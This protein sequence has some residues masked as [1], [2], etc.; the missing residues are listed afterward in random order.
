MENYYDLFQI[1]SNA[2]YNEIVNAYNI[3][4]KKYNYLKTLNENQINEIKILKKGLYILTSSE[5]KQK[6]DNKLFDNNNNN[7]DNLFNIDNSWM[8]KC[9]ITET[10]KKELNFSNRIFSLSE[11]NKKPNYPSD[12]RF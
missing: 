6:Y 7:L 5:L 4:I 12:L 8:D 3:K 10:N 1:N 2:K 11:I 9:Q